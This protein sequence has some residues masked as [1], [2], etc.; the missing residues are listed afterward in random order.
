MAAGRGR[1][2]SGGFPVAG[3]LLLLLPGA[4][5]SFLPRAT[6]YPSEWRDGRGAAR[7]AAPV[8]GGPGEG[9]AKPSAAEGP[10]LPG[11]SLATP[12]TG[13]ERPG[14]ARRREGGERH[15][16]A[17]SGWSV[18]GN[19]RGRPEEARKE[20]T[21]R[22]CLHKAASGLAWSWLSCRSLA[23]S[24]APSQR[25]FPGLV[26]DRSPCGAE[27]ALGGREPDRRRPGGG[28]RPSNGCPDV[29]SCSLPAF[30]RSSF[31]YLFITSILHRSFSGA[32]PL[33]YTAL[34]QLTYFCF[35]SVFTHS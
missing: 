5:L 34:V 6:P 20:A 24:S 30:L 21:G 12:R 4:L 32:R 31:L 9:P 15:L 27:I 19:G 3:L 28:W 25:S 7:A 16:L 1:R 35:Q 23:V 18:A 11:V 33:Q 22:S 29:C 10:G 2:P 14:P 8:Q 13:P 26:R 17:P